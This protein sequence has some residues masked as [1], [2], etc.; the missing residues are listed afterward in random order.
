M[1]KYTPSA[2]RSTKKVFDQNSALEAACDTSIARVTG[3]GYP[4]SWRMQVGHLPANARVKRTK[5]FSLVL[6]TETV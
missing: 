1:K 6:P 2:V 3:C 4:R 5:T